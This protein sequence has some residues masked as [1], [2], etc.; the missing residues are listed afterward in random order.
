MLI[1]HSTQYLLVFLKRYRL[2]L[3]LSDVE[4]KIMTSQSVTLQY[5]PCVFNKLCINSR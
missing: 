1:L 4:H 5:N 3:D 2:N